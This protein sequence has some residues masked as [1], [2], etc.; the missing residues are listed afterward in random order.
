MANNDM[1]DHLRHNMIIQDK[2]DMLENFPYIRNEDHV[3]PKRDANMIQKILEMHWT[4][5]NKE[6]HTLLQND[7]VEHH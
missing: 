5:K 1:L 7:L 3:E 6:M 2:R 4:H